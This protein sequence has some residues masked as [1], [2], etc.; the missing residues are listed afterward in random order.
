MN[1]TSGAGRGG[2]RARGGGVA[3]GRPARARVKS[4]LYSHARG[5]RC[6][7]RVHV[8]FPP[9]D[10]GRRTRV[11]VRACVRCAHAPRVR[12]RRYTTCEPPGVCARCPSELENAPRSSPGTGRTRAD[13]APKYINNRP[14]L[15]P[16]RRARLFTTACVIIIITTTTTTTTTISPRR[17]TSDVVNRRFFSLPRGRFLL[18]NSAHR[19]SSLLPLINI[20]Y[21]AH[22][23]FFSVPVLVKYRNRNSQLVFLEISILRLRSILVFLLRV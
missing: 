3:E 21:N 7:R 13:A 18:L 23:V 2:R 1:H 17:Q 20:T 6:T 4:I 9:G 5:R 10:D 22:I 19:K 11:T 8:V 15:F 16:S 12:T 14:S